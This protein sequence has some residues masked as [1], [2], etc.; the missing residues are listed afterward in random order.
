MTGI[1]KWFNRDLGYGFIL[2]A[3]KTEVFIHHSQIVG[4]GFRSLNTGDEVMFETFE[5]AKGVKAEKLIVTKKVKE[6]PQMARHH[7]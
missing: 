6:Q 1:V 2:A 3:D 4:K 7:E 5:D